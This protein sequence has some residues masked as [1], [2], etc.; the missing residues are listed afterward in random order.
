MPI[1]ILGWGVSIGT[2]SYLIFK[3]KEENIS[4]V[5]LVSAMFFVASMIYIP[6]GISSI[7]FMLLGVIGVLLGKDSL[8]AL[9]IALLLQS[10]LLGF[11]GV[12]SLGVNVLNLTFGAMSGY[13]L[14]LF[15]KDKLNEKLLYFL[16]GFTPIIVASLFLALSLLLSE[17]E[18]LNLSKI[19]FTLNLPLAI[20]EGFVSIFIFLFLKK[21][22]LKL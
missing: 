6:I 19:T 17:R 2:F 18:F 20:I 7:H 11:G 8:L 1:A 5:A 14:Y 9:F 4:K 16:I 12:S 22:N 21:F 13:Y 15:L 3:L 10:L